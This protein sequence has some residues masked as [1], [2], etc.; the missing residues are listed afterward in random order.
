MKHKH[1]AL[2]L[3]AI[4]T[5]TLILL[6]SCKK[7]NESTTLGSDLIPVVDNINT[8]DTILTVEAY[9]DTFSV[10]TDT[11][12][13]NTS[14]THYLGHIENDPFFGKTDAKLFLELLPPTAKYTFINRPDSLTID[15]VVLVLD[16][17]E[18]YGDTMALQTVNVYEIPQTSQFG[19]TSFTIRN[20]NF[21]KAGL[22]GSRTF[23]PV[24]L[25]D[26]VKVYQDTTANQLRIRL[27][28]AF[29]Q[30][31]LNYD[32]VTA[33]GHIN[34]YL[35]DST[36]RENFKGFAL[37]SASGNAIMGFNL[38]GTNTKLAIYYKDD[39]N[40]AD[41][42][43]ADTAV[44][45]FSFAT[46]LSSVAANYIVR[47]YSGTPL[48]A[49]ANG[50]TGSPDDLI[51]IQNTPGSFATLKIPGLAGLNNSVIHRAELIMEQVHHMDDTMFPPTNLY[52]DAYDPSISTFR[53]IPYDVAFDAQGNSN[54]HTA[55]GVI[56]VATKDLSG[57]S[58]KSWRFNL[59]RYI[60]HVVNDTEPVYDLRLF[61]P[62]YVNEHYRP[63]VAGTTSDLI[64]KFLGVPLQV[65]SAAGKGRV[66][67]GGG[68]HSTQKMRM[69]IVYSK[70]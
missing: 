49:T 68:N 8:F 51:Y 3:G 40:S 43:K 59:T 66:R 29:G 25:N 67:L 45:Y 41:P 2:T 33:N 19:D 7:I 26:S 61:A 55:F 24:I 31:L 22:L 39:N 20:N 70:I 5:S 65:N 15:S 54:I 46:N 35:S 28:D 56:P 21:E 12:R 1:L 52:L 37:E 50:V 69:R 11:T 47:D 63:G 42:A 13:Y 27:D 32:T 18:T 6:I 10:V 58:I 64:T 16:Y 14:Y 36:F 17:V 53:T 48:A 23:E 38:E 57:N 9:N 30:R 60:Q 44:A 4:F 34:A 62:L